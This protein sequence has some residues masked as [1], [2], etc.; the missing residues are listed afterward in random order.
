MCAKESTNPV[1]ACDGSRPPKAGGISE[2]VLLVV[3]EHLVSFRGGGCSS[4]GEQ[5]AMPSDPGIAHKLVSR[6][7]SPLSVSWIRLSKCQNERL[8][9]H[10]FFIAPNFHHTGI[11]FVDVL[12]VVPDRI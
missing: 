4:Y 6:T 7:P 11:T 9:G 12:V 5:V 3:S 2:S 1:L 8:L 10:I